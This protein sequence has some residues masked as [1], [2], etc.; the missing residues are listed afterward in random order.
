MNNEKLELL[1]DAVLGMIVLEYL[2]KRFF[3]LSEGEIV[4][5]K[6]FVVSE[7]SLAIF[8]SS[9]DLG[10]YLL[11]S[12]GEDNTGGRCRPSILADAFEAIIGAIYLDGGF[13]AAK[14]FL[15]PLLIK[16]VDSINSD[17]SSVDYKTLLQ[18]YS[19][20]QFKV[21]PEYTILNEYGPDHDK[22]FKVAAYIGDRFLAEAMGSSKKDAEQNAAKLACKVLNIKSGKMF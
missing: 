7:P 15:L 6:S 21:V 4:K 10:R 12:K 17:D 13:I 18:E 9:I 14:G 1:G 3:N 20:S 11:L 5:I 22:K 2:Y 16:K 19:Q 8:A